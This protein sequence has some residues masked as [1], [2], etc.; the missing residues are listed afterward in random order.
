MPSNFIDNAATTS[1]TDQASN[2][3]GQGRWWILTIPKDSFEAPSAPPTGCSYA[4]GQ[5]EIGTGGFEHWQVVACFNKKVRLRGVKAVFGK[6]A[7]CEL[8]RSPAANAYVWKDETAVEGTRFE[9]GEA[10]IKRNDATDWAKVKACAKGG[11]IDDV[12][13]DI[14][15][16]HYNVLKKIA[17]DHLEF[18]DVEK[19]VHCYWGVS[20][21][22]KSHRA[23]EEAGKNVYIKDPC[24]KWWC[25][26]RPAE[27]DSVLIE[28]FTGTINISH[29]LRWLDKWGSAVETKLGG[30]PFKA[31]KIWI[32]SNVN[33][34]LWYP[35]A[36]D[37]QRAALM[38]R[39][40]VTEFKEVYKPPAPQLPAND[41]RRF[42]EAAPQHDGIP[43]GD[44]MDVPEWRDYLGDLLD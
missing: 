20:G 43:I 21:S 31:P 33:P 23:R 9:V 11:K 35:D 8:S 29:M 37:Q 5:L 13:D 22:G 19:T 36:N 16:K 3:T 41:N 10:P 28:E 15:I 32:T 12:P 1:N 26:Y 24:T 39:M 14:Y 42:W 44:I 6:T 34:L 18:E 38:R 7:H 40:K 4:K 27:H 30:L 17:L 2:T 25:G